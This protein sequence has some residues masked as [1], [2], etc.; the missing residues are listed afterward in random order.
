MEWIKVQDDL[1]KGEW[2]INYTY[3][4]EEVLVANSAGIL[5]GFYCRKDGCWYTGDLAHEDWIDKVT[6]WMPLPA[7]PHEVVE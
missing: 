4:S 2:G 7:S 6:H 5:I 3:L 1:P